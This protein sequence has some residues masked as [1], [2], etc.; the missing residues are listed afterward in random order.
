M[1]IV[2]STVPAIADAHR[3]ILAEAGVLEILHTADLFDYYYY[4]TLIL[5]DA[6]FFFVTQ[7]F[8]IFNNNCKPWVFLGS[9]FFPVNIV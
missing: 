4:S 3:A 7:N 6:M 5:H 8:G 2:T 9:L 1:G